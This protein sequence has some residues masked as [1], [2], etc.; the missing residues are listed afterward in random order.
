MKYLQVR[1]LVNQKEP[2]AFPK[3]QTKNMLRHKQNGMEQYQRESPTYLL[4][5]KE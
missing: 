1:N 5:E 2:L 3:Q 4:K